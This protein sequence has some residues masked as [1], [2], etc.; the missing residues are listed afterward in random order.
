MTQKRRKSYKDN[1][2]A[3][4]LDAVNRITPKENL[5]LSGGGSGVGE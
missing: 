5:L 3:F 1:P 2:Q 4:A